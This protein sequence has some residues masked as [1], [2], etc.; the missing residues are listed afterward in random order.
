MTWTVTS[1]R[2]SLAVLQEVLLSTT[3]VSLA[4]LTMRNARGKVRIASKKL[5]TWAWVKIKPPTKT[6]SF[7]RVP[8]S[9][10]PFL[11]HSHL[12]VAELPDTLS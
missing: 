9:G 10:Y 1:N 2:N 12:K 11:T 6:A 5:R 8:F 4:E 3:E 7:G